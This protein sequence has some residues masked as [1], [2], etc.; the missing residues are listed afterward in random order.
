MSDRVEISELCAEDVD[1]ALKQLWMGAIREG[2]LSVLP[3]EENADKWIKL[4]RDGLSKGRDLLLTAKAGSKTVGYVY[5]NVSQ[6]SFFERS[7]SFCF[8]N[9]MYVVP[10]FRG[11]G[12]GTRLVS[13]C[14]ALMK[15]RGFKAVRLNVLPSNEIALRLYEKFGFEIF[16]YGMRL[17]LKSSV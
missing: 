13:K 5:A 1:E 4:V 16:M 6:E 9:D 14:L 12:I 8:L 17:A 10:E 3:T 7:G 11:R 15:A 2:S